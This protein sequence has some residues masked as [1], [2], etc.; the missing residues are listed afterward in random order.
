MNG[1]SQEHRAEGQGRK[2]FQ[3]SKKCF[4]IAY[5]SIDCRPVEKSKHIHNFYKFP[6]RFMVQS[7]ARIK[8]TTTSRK[9]AGVFRFFNIFSFSLLRKLC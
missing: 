7:Q 8:D 2:Q 6:H 9:K 5:G 4:F 1:V 3:N